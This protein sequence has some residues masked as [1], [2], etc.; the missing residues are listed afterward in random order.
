MN[1]SHNA[2]MIAMVPTIFVLLT[3]AFAGP[4]S[5]I[6]VAQIVTGTPG[7]V[8]T[9][10]ES[11]DYSPPVNETGP[12]TIQTLENVEGSNA[13]LLGND[14][15][16]SNPNITAADAG[17]VNSQEECLRLSNQSAVDCP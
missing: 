15:N 4:L 17:T 14:T 11:E 1:L 5:G 6:A 12:E 2:L 8:G 7:E 13:A 3:T 9:T 10:N 16:I